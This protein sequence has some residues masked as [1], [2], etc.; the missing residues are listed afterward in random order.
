M[1]KKM[2]RQI[3]RPETKPE[4][5][6]LAKKTKTAHWMFHVTDVEGI[7]QIDVWDAVAMKGGETS[8][9]YRMFFA[10][11]DYIT[12]DLSVE[13]T[14]WLTG[15]AYNILEFYWCDR[16]NEDFIIYVD[17]QSREI[18]ESRFPPETYSYTLEGS[19]SFKSSGKSGTSSIIRFVCSSSLSC[20]FSSLFFRIPS[21]QS[22]I[23]SI[24]DLNDSL[25]SHV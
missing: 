14:K 22:L 20:F 25:P 24:E 12:Q 5:I 11:D 9:K 8:A 19:E 2:L 10:E 23:G 15:K 6:E 21:C 1:D 3:P 4:Y 17:D 13:K 16:K 18:L 7:M